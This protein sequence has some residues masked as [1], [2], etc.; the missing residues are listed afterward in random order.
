MLN[1]ARTRTVYLIA[2]LYAALLTAPLVAQQVSEEIW[3]D[4]RSPQEFRQDH[5]QG[6]V[7]IPFMQI[8][9]RITEITRDKQANI[10]LYCTVGTRAAIA[11]QILDSMGFENVVNEGGL[12]NLKSSK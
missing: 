10:R 2:L 7:N 1:V 12:E 4:V 8:M 6:A 5:R 9:Q 11:K 3:I